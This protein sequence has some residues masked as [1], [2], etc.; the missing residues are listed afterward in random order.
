MGG[1]LK[2]SGEVV[3]NKGN[4]GKTLNGMTTLN[5]HPK[6]MTVSFVVLLWESNMY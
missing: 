2:A 4:D 3:S 1:A 5:R 6:P